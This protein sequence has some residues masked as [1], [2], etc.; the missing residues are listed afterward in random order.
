MQA[1]LQRVIQTSATVA[2]L[3]SFLLAQDNAL[4][5]VAAVLERIAA[6]T[7]SSKSAGADAEFAAGQAELTRATTRQ[8]ARVALF[9][10]FTVTIQT[11]HAAVPSMVI[12]QSNLAP[13]ID[14]VGTAPDL[15]RLEEPVVRTALF[16]V[17]ALRGQNR[18]ETERLEQA[19]RLL[20]VNRA[21]LEAVTSLPAHL[22]RVTKPIAGWRLPVPAAPPK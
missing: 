15:G 10:G 12:S 7:A 4:R 14:A 1:A 5:T 13:A 6:L 18:A 3:T 9:G 11:G 21:N 17:A 8:F 16:A 2:R 19:G 20:A 22:E